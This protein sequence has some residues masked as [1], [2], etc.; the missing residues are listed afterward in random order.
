MKAPSETGNPA[1]NSAASGSARRTRSERPPGLRWLWLVG[2]SLLMAVGLGGSALGGVAW[3]HSQRNQEH[4]AF[5]ESA[6][7]AAAAVG[8]SLHRDLDFI[9][10]QQAI[11]V[12]FPALTNRQLAT[13][14]RSVDVKK[15]FP[16][17][18]AFGFVEPIPAADLPAFLAEIRADPPVGRSTVADAPV[19]PGARAEYCIGRF[20][21][22]MTP[23]FPAT[24]DLCA[25]YVTGTI[26]SP[27]P[28]GMRYATDTG[29]TVVASWRTIGKDF[30]PIIG[31]RAA[32]SLSTLFA[33][34]VPVYDGGGTPTTLAGRRSALKGWM[35][36]DLSSTTL[37]NSALGSTEL[38]VALHFR[39]PDGVGVA[40]GSDGSVPKGAHFVST[41]VL[42]NPTGW[43]VVITGSATSDALLQGLVIGLM[44]A[45]LVALLF[46]YLFHLVRSRERAFRL[47]AQRT[48]QLQHQALHDPLT[49][50][51]NRALIF[52]RA[53]QMLMRAKRQPLA[54][55]AL[56]VD[57]DNFKEIN[58]TFGHYVGDQL[59][60][61]VASRLA[62]ALRLSDTVGRLGG[63]EFLVLVEGDTSDAGPEM[64]AQ[65]LHAALAEPFLLEVPEPVE[66]VVRASIGVAIGPRSTGD[67][68][69]RDADVALYQAK[70]AGRDRIVVFRPEM[71]T[72]IKD[73]LG[74]EM[75]LRLAID[76]GQLFVLYQPIFDLTTMTAKGVEALVRWQHP[77]RGVILPD[78][79]IPMAEET[80]LIVRLGRF[81][82]NTACAQAGAWL[83]EGYQIGV[84]VNISARQFDDATFV[85]DVRAA[86][87][88][89]GI[90]PSLL[91]LEIAETTL[92]EDTDAAAEMLR[93][94]NEVGVHL[95]ID[96]FGTG[97]SSL[98]YLRRFTIDS[99]KIDRSF[100]TRVS[101]SAESAELIHTL[102]QLGKAL[103]I[104]TLA[105]GVEE[106][107]QLAQMQR[108][109]CDSAQGFLFARPLPPASIAAFFSRSPADGAGAAKEAVR[110][111]TAV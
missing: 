63:D 89:A 36:G 95:S 85:D 52:D 66:L 48:G 29:Q 21:I 1:W 20:G 11:V 14:Y 111:T 19:P 12:A 26:R 47:V 17:S 33:I 2:A 44:G 62:S 49:D 99:L 91:T 68:L 82:L 46:V 32:R 69:I 8:S 79:F 37:I 50:L 40:V 67:E 81:V 28:K 92:M 73:R 97:Y 110:S 4:D 72:A 55:G 71:Q 34:V 83:A 101:E 90:D 70:E 76:D 102:I 96:D 31:A 59:L 77:T 9:A 53:Q 6:A 58:D 64:A 60:R 30:E 75:D 27:I 57:L 103:G 94:L 105:E 38:G 45:V 86:L 18:V 107:S 84:A 22:L 51:P 74:L 78:D 3:Y 56:Y 109:Q 65:R 10:A 23:L 16:G 100:I 35:V 43:S 7:D 61:S 41:I 93:E 106:E 87:D 104:E 25:P 24:D 108:E 42:S 39:F 98:S 88:R 13:W 5:E 80:G 15:S 54:I